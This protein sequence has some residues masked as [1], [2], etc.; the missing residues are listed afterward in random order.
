MNMAF[1]IRIWYSFNILEFA[2]KG[3]GSLDPSIIFQRSIDAN[4][5][6]ILSFQ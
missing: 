5:V 3:G 6:L 2:L 4:N 1:L